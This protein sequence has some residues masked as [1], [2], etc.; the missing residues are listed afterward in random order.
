MTMRTVINPKLSQLMA[1]G[2][3]LS[4]EYNRANAGDAWSSGNFDLFPAGGGQ[5][6]ALIKKIRPVKEIIEGMVS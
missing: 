6:S 5:V 3:D 1:T 4:K 2:A